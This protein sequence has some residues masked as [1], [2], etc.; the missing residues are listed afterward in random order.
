MYVMLTIAF[1]KLWKLTN[2]HSDDYG[3]LEPAIS[4]KIME[5]HHSKHH[6][7]YVTSFN[8]A[9]D[10]FQEA[11]KKNDIKAQVALQSLI[12]FHGGGHINHSLFWENLAP[13]SAGGG[14][15]PS[16]ALKVRLHILPSMMVLA[17][18]NPLQLLRRVSM[19]MLATRLPSRT[20]TAPSPSS[21]APSTLLLPESKAAAGHGS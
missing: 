11:E 17:S 16:G 12:N 13:K 3:A 1:G 2:V 4:G 6:Q 8:T 5:L 21:K 10:Q 18:T 15:E 7:T 9:N 19:L 14:G 20:R